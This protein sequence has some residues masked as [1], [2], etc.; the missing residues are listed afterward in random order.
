MEIS[1]RGETYISTFLNVVTDHNLTIALKTQVIIITTYY[2]SFKINNNS[3]ISSN[4][5]SMFQFSVA[6]D[7]LKL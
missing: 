5:E 6:E 1:L 3:L 2:Y 7:V 4:S